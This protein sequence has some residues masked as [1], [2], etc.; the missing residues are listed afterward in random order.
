MC[1]TFWVIVLKAR[2][3]KTFFEKSNGLIGKDKP[4][5]VFFTTRWGIHTFGVKFSLDIVV[6]DSKNQVVSLKKELKPSRF[7][8]WN[9]MYF[10]ILELPRGTIEKLKIQKGSLIKITFLSSSTSPQQKEM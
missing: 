7:F 4:E 1:Y 9:P 8:M 10:N 6:M 3:L 2:L 5:S